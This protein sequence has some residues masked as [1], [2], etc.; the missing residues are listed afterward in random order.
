MAKANE[1]LLILSR[2][3]RTLKGLAPDIRLRVLRWLND[4]YL[5]PAKPNNGDT[6]H[7]AAGASCKHPGFGGAA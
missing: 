7:T 4:K 5:S 1:E 2:L 6:E 3:D